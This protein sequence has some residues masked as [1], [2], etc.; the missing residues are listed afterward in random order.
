MFDELKNAADKYFSEEFGDSLI[1]VENKEYSVYGSGYS[2]YKGLAAAMEFPFGEIIFA[3]GDL[4]F[5]RHSFEK[6]YNSPKNAVTC[7][8]EPI[9][10]SKAVAFF[11]DMNDEIHYIYDTGHNSMKIDVPFTAIY[12]SGQVWKFSDPDKLREIF[13]STV[14]EE[15]TGTNLVFIE[16]YFRAVCR[17][18]YRL[19]CFKDWINCNTVDDFRRIPSDDPCK[20]EHL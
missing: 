4:Y 13:D 16:K 6:I 9:L 12:N 14:S 19:I 7:C 1:L 8:S 18:D 3:E 20:E 5:D 11:F 17:S 10:A 2:L 15:W